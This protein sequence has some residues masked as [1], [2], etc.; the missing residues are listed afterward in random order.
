[1]GVPAFF[2]WI[3][4]RYPK[5]LLDA[6]CEDDRIELYKEYEQ[7]VKNQEDPNNIDLGVDVSK[8]HTQFKAK[9]E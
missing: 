1:M 2:K 7:E 8:G 9:G 6:I 5:V 3:T 4:V